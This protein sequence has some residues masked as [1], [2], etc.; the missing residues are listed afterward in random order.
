MSEDKSFPH[1]PEEML[2]HLIWKVR[3]EKR[4]GMLC[5]KEVDF[6]N[7]YMEKLPQEIRDEYGYHDRIDAKFPPPEQKSEV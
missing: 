1:T 5:P 6:F 4:E 2:F 3:R 7:E